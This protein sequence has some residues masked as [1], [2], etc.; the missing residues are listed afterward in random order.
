VPAGED[1]DIAAGVDAGPGPLSPGQRT[2]LTR[3]VEQARSICGY[4]FAIWIGPLGE[5]PDGAVAQHAGL[6]FASSTVL[7][8]VDPAAHRI[9]IVTGANVA[10]V[11]DDRTAEFAALAMKSCFVA[12][13]LV[14]GIREGVLLLA[15]H[16]RHPR[17][18]HL[19]ND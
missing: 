8:A 2:Q 18:L 15:E 12:N 10:R 3:L 17:V 19:N 14:G 6:P 13:D 7:V 9:E 16:S 11:L 4:A 1:Y 5:G